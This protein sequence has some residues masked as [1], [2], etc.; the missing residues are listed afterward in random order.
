MI[1]LLRRFF[2]KIR[3]ILKLLRRNK[4]YLGQESYFPEE[5]RKTKWSMLIDHI[6]FILKYGEMPRFYFVY[7][8]DRVS[9]NKDDYM[10]YSSF[11][12]LRQRKNTVRIGVQ[13]P[14]SYVCLLRDKELFGW[15]S[16]KLEIPTPKSLGTLQDGVFTSN[17]SMSFSDFCNSMEDNSALFLKEIAG[18]KGSGAFAI[19]KKGGIYYINGESVAVDEI[20]GRIPSRQRFIVQKRVEQHSAINKIYPD[21]LNTVR[22]VSVVNGNEIVILGSLLRIGANGSV[23]DN[24]AHGGVAVGVNSDG[25]LM[26]WGLY[27]PSYGTKT[28]RHPNSGVIFEEYRLPFWEETLALVKESHRK[29]SCIATIG[30]DIAITEMGPVVIEGNDDYD[31]ALLQACTGGKKQDFLKYY[32]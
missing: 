11:M 16:E 5:K 26:K 1:R 22:V 24:W 2:L 15:I 4:R 23:V 7:G 28:D 21:A 29:L 3:L 8:L 13:S 6:E 31:G 25:T 20:I 27:K 32:S 17:R 10:P 30:W 18:Y 19:E 9:A 12:A 14:Y